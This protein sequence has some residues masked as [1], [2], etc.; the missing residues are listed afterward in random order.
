MKNKIVVSVILIMGIISN[1]N[2]TANGQR[3]DLAKV[4]IIAYDT[5]GIRLGAPN[6]MTF[7]SEH[8]ENIASQFHMGTADN[9][10]FGIY[11]IEAWLPAY[12]SEVR[13]VRVY[14]RRVTI[15]LG[16]N[17]GNELPVVAP[18]FSGRVVGLNSGKNNNVFAKLFGVF[19]N[20][21]LES[22]INSDGEFEVAGVT[23]G[24]YI[25]L[26]VNEKG[27]LAS[28]VISMPYTG[29]FSINVDKSQ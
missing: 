25:L 14:Q 4:E 20:V 17:I 8:H 19:S 3:K 29:Y 24:Q 6:V 27:V 13:Y 12:S 11:R 16:L 26:I 15:V 21:S 7:E 2:Q 9:I 23:D 5:R 28:R 1:L 22:T 10:P 18:T